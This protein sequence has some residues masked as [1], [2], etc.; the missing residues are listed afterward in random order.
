MEPLINL[1]LKDLSLLDL[2]PLS[3]DAAFSSATPTSLLGNE[4][5]LFIK[6]LTQE[7]LKDLLDYLVLG[8][9]L[10]PNHLRIWLR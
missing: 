1:L 6:L 9:E 10:L 3:L 2:V 5:A 7:F 4:I 8:F